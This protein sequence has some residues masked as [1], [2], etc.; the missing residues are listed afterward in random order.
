MLRILASANEGYRGQALASQL[1]TGE[2][3]PTEVVPV[4]AAAPDKADTASVR[5]MQWGMLSQN[6]G[7]VII[8]A[9]SESAPEK[10]MFRQS[11]RLGRALVPASNF[12]EWRK[13]PDSKKKTRVCLGV[14]GAD[15]FSMAGLW[16]SERLS[17]A[18]A[19]KLYGEPE[20]EA[21]IN[22]FVIITMAASEWMSS[23]H[24][25]MPL[26]LTREAGQSWLFDTEAALEILAN[27][28]A[29]PLAACDRII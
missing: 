11:F 29:S 16:R 22:R 4:V 5:L 17:S 8:N 28:L 23:I 9:R 6:F 15:L 21:V 10:P 24:D 25:R 26:I 7:R 13:Q 18:D 14:P 3:F 2:I 19:E 12:F 27:P 20:S 1:K